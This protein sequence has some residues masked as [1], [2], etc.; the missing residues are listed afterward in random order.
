MHHETPATPQTSFIPNPF[1]AQ[2]KRQV[3]QGIRVAPLRAC[4]T[5]LPCKAIFL[6]FRDTGATC[7]KRRSTHPLCD[8]RLSTHAMP[9]HIELRQPAVFDLVFDSA[10]DVAFDVAFE[11]NSHVALP[12][13]RGGKWIRS[14]ACLSRRRVCFTSHFLFRTIGYPQGSDFASPSFAYLFLAKQEK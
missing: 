1:S 3:Q 6:P 10:F 2:H 12:I 11:S 5:E 9:K 13:V 7:G 8:F 14:E 4:V